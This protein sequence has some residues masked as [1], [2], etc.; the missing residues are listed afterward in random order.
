MLYEYDSEPFPVNLL[1]S[2][3]QFDDSPAAQKEYRR[4]AW[5]LLAVIIFYGIPAFQLVLTYQQLLSV[6][7]NQDICYY[8]TLCSHPWYINSSHTII[9]FNN[10]FS[11]IGYFILGV[12]VILLT[13]RRRVIYR[14]LN[15]PF[16]NP[17][18]TY[19]DEV[20]NFLTCFNI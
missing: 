19:N 7:G 11:N 4:Y 5:Y 1:M 15:E 20:G 3:L 13:Y 18:E 9:A 8:N 14:D 6:S 2:E 16:N 17:Q 10:I 12:L